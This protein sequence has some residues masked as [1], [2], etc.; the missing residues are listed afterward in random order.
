[1]KTQNSVNGS[2]N[3]TET[4][5]DEDDL[6]NED[7]YLNIDS[8]DY[9]YPMKKDDFD[10]LNERI[11]NFEETIEGK[12]KEDL[13]TQISTEY[14]LKNYPNCEK[15]AL[16][17]SHIISR[18]I[19]ENKKLSK[20]NVEKYIDYFYALRYEI[21]YS[22]SLKLNKEGFRNLGYIFCFIF[23]K[24]HKY[25]IGEIQILKALI[26]S[27]IDNHIDVITDFYEYCA[28]K[29]LDPGDE[30]VKKTK[31]WDQTKHNYGLPPEMIFLINLFQRIDTLDINI[32]F[33][34]E[35]LDDD[36]LKLFTITMFNIHYILAS[37]ETV[38]TNFIHNKLQYNL[39]IRYYQKLLNILNNNKECLKKNKVQNI[40]SIYDRKWDFQHDFNLEIF[41]INEE[42]RSSI[43]RSG[44]TT[45]DRFSIMY[46]NQPQK[47]NLGKNMF[48]TTLQ[49]SVNINELNISKMV[50]EVEDYSADDDEDD[51]SSILSSMTTIINKTKLQKPATV[52][53]DKF[54]KLLEIKDKFKDKIITPYKTIDLTGKIY[55]ELIN[56]YS[57][58]FDVML[59]TFSSISRL[60]SIKRIDFVSNDFY[61]KEVIIYLKNKFGLD[62]EGIDRE[63]HPL[64]II[65]KK[66]KHLEAL[67]IEINSLD[68]MVFQKI[69]GIIYKNSDLKCLKLSLFTSEV[70]Y[71]Q[72][73][74]LKLYEQIMTDKDKEY[75]KNKGNKINIDILEEK[76]LNELQPYFTEN[77]SLLFQII[78]LKTDLETIGFN[79]DLPS[80]LKTKMNYKTPI[81]KFMFNILFFVDNA[82]A[83]KNRIK[84]LV[85]LCPGLILDN[86]ISNNMD[87]YF[88]DIRIYKKNK[89]LKEINIQFEFY[90]IKSITHLISPNLTILSLGDLDFYTF[91]HVVNY[92]TEYKVSTTLNLKE[93][94][95][96]LVKKIIEFNTDLKLLLAKLFNIKIST[97]LEMKLFT[98]IL[99]EDKKDYTYI[100]KIIKN[101][102]ISSYIITFHPDS[103]SILNSFTYLNEEITFMV[104]HI[105]ESQLFDK[106]EL[107]KMSNM[108]SPD[109]KDEIFWYLKYIFTHRYYSNTQNF[110]MIKDITYSIL[111]Y[112]YYTKNVKIK[113]EIEE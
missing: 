63:F 46:Y 23:E 52:I 11:K 43:K 24:F 19:R 67:N 15:N 86:R 66:S 94:S 27:V 72:Q 99:L 47:E 59:I 85:L 91:E 74:L 65:Y 25:K 84:K 44:R 30:K 37:L 102:W 50:D 68:V 8:K 62:I 75:L 100:I 78:K 80:V 4:S 83:N 38:K 73:S 93:L 16:K 88:R 101:N 55:L 9:F 103:D 56:N 77:L 79:F 18:Q 32:F 13:T 6:I 41:R 95:L 10:S 51:N 3:S 26:K 82:K 22:T 49:K 12:N 113:H 64:D 39:Y 34:G 5:I 57:Y 7:I 108:K 81:M 98:N 104:P 105:L 97:L 14:M 40:N 36:D 111:K 29:G 109:N 28:K 110:S 69:L 87:N 60:T 42:N 2:T 53:K 33:G 71:F 21:K 45:C 89:Y 20:E 17:I 61:S 35:T 112:L 90:K 58:I 107:S 1:M 54:N 106:D 70:S 31:I 48:N 92:I 96:S 76:M